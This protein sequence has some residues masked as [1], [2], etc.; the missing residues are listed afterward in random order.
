MTGGLD[1]GFVSEFFGGVPGEFAEGFGLG[2]GWHFG[3]RLRVGGD[4][5]F[6]HGDVICK[7]AHELG[8][9]GNGNNGKW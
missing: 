7:V 1:V 2:W 9:K 5:Y 4:Q 6:R 8:K 3:K